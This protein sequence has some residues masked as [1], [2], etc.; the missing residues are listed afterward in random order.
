MLSSAKVA[1]ARELLLSTLI[2]SR[3]ASSFHPCLTLADTRSGLIVTVE[4]MVPMV[5]T[6]SFT[7]HLKQKSTGL[8][9]VLAGV[10]PAAT[11]QRLAELHRWLDAGYAGQMSYMESRRAAYQHPRH[12]LEGC[13][14]VLMLAL[15]YGGNG[16]Q[17]ESAE[18][19]RQPR[20]A[21]AAR[22]GKVAQYA[23]GQLDY[24]DVIHAKLK[25]L[26]AWC[27]EHA[28]QASFRGVVDTAPLLEREL[29]EAAGL[30]WVGKNTLLLNRQWGSYFF[31]AALLTDL[32]LDYDAPHEKGYCGSCTA[33][34]QACPT[35]AFPAPFVL[36][37]TKCISYL[38]IEHRDDIDASLSSRLDGWVFGCDVCQQ[39]CPWNR[40][41]PD[42]S[43]SAF[44]PRDDLAQLDVLAVLALSDEDF[45]QQ[46]R[47]TPLW[48]AKRR[49]LLRNTILIAATAKMPA[50]YPLIEKLL[51]D[52]EPLIRAAAGWA[53]KQ[54]AATCSG[55]AGTE[56]LDE[57]NRGSRS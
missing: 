3:R 26:R 39:V 20:D 19:H 13:R 5:P 16:G 12:V 25:T 51:D 24:H 17:T 54:Y 43:E 47:R 46:F 41:P 52:A 42:S 32:E 22:V 56:P 55:T 49:G 23:Q 9:F 29:A 50:A 8:G 7:T 1:S 53:V 2:P 28:P 34:L 4:S 15:P 45:R 21:N 10:T 30:G 31:L 44:A 35:Q 11:P 18:K 27:A 6:V 33:C 48:R 38:T 14:S 37:A 57:S 40:Q 36:D